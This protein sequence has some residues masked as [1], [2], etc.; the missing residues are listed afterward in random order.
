MRIVGSDSSHCIVLF[1]LDRVECDLDGIDSDEEI[2]TVYA[3]Y[4]SCSSSQRMRSCGSRG[5]A[6]LSGVAS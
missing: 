5:G 3:V 1:V 4:Y 6:E 2:T